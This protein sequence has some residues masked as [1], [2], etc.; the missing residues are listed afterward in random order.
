MRAQHATPK[1]AASQT[2]KQTN[3]TRSTGT[4]ADKMHATNPIRQRAKKVTTK[5][6]KNRAKVEKQI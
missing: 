6:F 1:Q 4:A 2:A 3:Q 5:I